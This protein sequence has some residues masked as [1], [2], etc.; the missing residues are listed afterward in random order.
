ML[1]ERK[2]LLIIKINIPKKREEM[3]ILNA[4]TVIVFVIFC[5]LHTS[6]SA[7][8]DETLSEVTFTKDS[9]DEGSEGK[10]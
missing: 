3:S 1:E 9:E 8:E 6:A 4:T 2:L 10:D 7:N 5:A